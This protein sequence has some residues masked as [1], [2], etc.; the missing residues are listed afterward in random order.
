MSKVPNKLDKFMYAIMKE[1][2]RNSLVE[3]LENYGITE[4]EYDKIESWFNENLKISL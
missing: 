3:L 2:R 4:E 1:A